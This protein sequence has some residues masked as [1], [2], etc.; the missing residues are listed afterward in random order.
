MRLGVNSSSADLT[1]GISPP[2]NYLNEANS[3][4]GQDRLRI[5]PFMISAQVSPSPTGSF[6]VAMNAPVDV[7]P[8]CI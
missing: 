7:V 4:Y 5:S 8:Q 3:F 6:S 2:Q 1:F